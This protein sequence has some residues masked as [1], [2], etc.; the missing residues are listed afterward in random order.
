MKTKQIFLFFFFVLCGTFILKGQGNYL[1]QTP[2][3][4]APIIFAPGIISTQYHE[5]SFP[6][7]SP[8]GKTI[9]W[10]IE[11]MG[12]YTYDFPSK[13]SVIKMKNKIWQESEYFSAINLPTSASAYYSPDG[14][15]I[16]FIS[17]TTTLP[18][19]RNLDIWVIEKNNKNWSKPTKLP[20]HINSQKHETQVSVTRDGT[21]YFAGYMEGVR[22][23]RG[24]YRSKFI[25]G[26]Y[27]FAEA[28]PET[29]NS[30]ELDWTPF[31]SPD[32]SYLLFCSYREGGNG[33]G[34]IYI[35]FR[36]KNDNWS[37]AI[38]LGSTIND[39][40]N[41]RFPYVSPDGKYL[42]FLSDKVSEE[43]LSKKELNYKDAVHYFSK[44]GNGFCDIYWVKADFIEKLRPNL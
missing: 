1:G 31:I 17:D 7:F 8:D 3:E 27:E 16:F 29:I 26:K 20:D 28:L 2:P 24:I 23:N 44:S 22:N 19:D 41:N 18:R 21:L 14:N 9:L 37:E 6:S 42:F 5:H 25:N 40:Y 10:N 13:V 34:D 33:S 32:E 35:S 36:D 11:F 38:N 39:K 15:K 12:N 4:N 30:K 43:L